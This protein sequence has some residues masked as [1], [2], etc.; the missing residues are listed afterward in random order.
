MKT[1]NPSNIFKMIMNS[2]DIV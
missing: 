2:Q 1:A